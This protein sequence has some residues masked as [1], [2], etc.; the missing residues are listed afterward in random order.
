[1]KKSIVFGIPEVTAVLEKI[2]P[3]HSRRLI[4]AT[5]RGVAAQVRTRARAKA[6][7][8]MGDLKKGI[9][10]YKPR[11]HKDLPQFQIK[12]RQGKGLKRSAFHWRFVEYGTGGGRGSHIPFLTGK[13]EAPLYKGAKPFLQP[14]VHEV[15]A[16]IEQIVKT[17]FSDKLERA[18][19]R[20]LKKARVPK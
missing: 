2:T 5:L 3:V 18:I 10:V 16:N 11:T 4:N 1:M 8:D 12:F 20:E 17:Q 19:Q 14:A 15:R 9:Y 13:K 6:P 7:V